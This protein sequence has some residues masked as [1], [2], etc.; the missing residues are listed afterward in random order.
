MESGTP[1]LAAVMNRLE[2]LEKQNRRMKQVGAVALVLIGSVLLMGQVAPYRTVEANR[3]MLKDAF[4]RTR[5][6]LD[7]NGLSFYDQSGRD[8]AS[9]NL[10]RDSSIF[11]LR[12]R[13]RRSFAE[14][15]VGESGTHLVIKGENRMPWTAP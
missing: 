1:E 7:I 2:R 4:G 6:E 8:L 11:V 13:H 3:F 5:A 14:F 15:D 9:L 12:D 10:G